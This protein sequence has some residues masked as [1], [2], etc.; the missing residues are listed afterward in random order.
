[1]PPKPRSHTILLVV[2]VCL[3]AF[4]LYVG[5][6]KLFRMDGFIRDVANYRIVGAPWDAVVGF[7]LP[8]LE[9]VA[10]L[11]LMLGWLRQGALLVLGGLTLVFMAGIGQAWARGLSISC[12]C[13][14][15]S[16][17]PSNY[18]LHLALNAAILAT[19]AVLLLDGRRLRLSAPAAAA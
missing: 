16:A 19:I 10:G 1:M 8:W 5:G 3:G 4:F 2:R 7:T 15:A 12:G 14:G 9:I 11:L 6:E 18:P 13:F 17:E